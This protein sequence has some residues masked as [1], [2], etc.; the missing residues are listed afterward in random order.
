MSPRLV[1]GIVALASGSICGLIATLASFEMV[2]QVNTRLPTEVQFSPL[3][4]YLPKTFRLHREYRRLF[5]EGKLLLR[6]RFLMSIAFGCL[7]ISAWA[8]GLFG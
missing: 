6:V 8:I 1:V 5:P 2:E 7:M 4:W 3:G